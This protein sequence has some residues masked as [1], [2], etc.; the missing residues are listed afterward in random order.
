MSFFSSYSSFP[1]IILYKYL[2]KVKKEPLSPAPLVNP[3]LSDEE[4]LASLMATSQFAPLT[5]LYRFA[6]YI[7]RNATC[8]SPVLY[9]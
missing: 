3:D 8:Q 4:D 5:T 7:D 9:I 1:T 2:L 6:I